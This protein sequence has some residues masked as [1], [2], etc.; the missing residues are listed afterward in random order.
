MNKP[1]V[2][3]V[4]KIFKDVR[5]TLSKHSPVILTGVGIAGMITTTVLAVKATPKALKLIEEEKKKERTDKL[6]PIETVKVTWKCYIPA[7][8]TGVTSTACLI[9]ANS[10]NAK[11][12]AA[13]AT[14]YQLSKTALTEYKEK[15]VE[16]IG[17][18]KEA[19]IREEIAKDKIEKDPVS[20]TQVIITGKGDTLCYDIQVGR[21]FKSDQERI[22]KAINEL[23]RKMIYE[24]YISL[25]EFYYELGLDGT[26]L[27]D[28]LGWNLDDG[29]IE[30][31]F[32]AQLADD[33]TPCI[34]MDY[35]IAPRYDY[36]KLM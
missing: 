17:E 6:T 3:K 10:V 29:L 32:S 21:Y 7:V 12:N 14:A 15:V 35:N 28:A 9:G 19:V 30:V 33:G 13:L 36:S 2:T 26:R 4:T 24:N 5:N 18:K 31:D 16:T 23:N 20:N 27:G 11:R 25:N 8:A 1:N 22:K 34:A